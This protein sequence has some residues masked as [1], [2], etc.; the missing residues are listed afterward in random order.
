MFNYQA[1]HTVVTINQ[2]NIQTS[3]IISN[4]LLSAIS[5]GKVRIRAWAITQITT[6]SD[7]IELSPTRQQ[8][9]SHA[10]RSQVKLVQGRSILLQGQQFFYIEFEMTVPSI[11]A[12]YLFRSFIKL[13][14]NAKDKR[15]GFHPLCSCLYFNLLL[16]NLTILSLWMIENYPVTF[17]QDFKVI[18]Y[19]LTTCIAAESAT[20]SRTREVDSGF[21]R[22][23][24]ESKES[25]KQVKTNRF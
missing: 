20:D 12:L 25:R 3:T 22:D 13:A 16:A 1:N 23:C 9:N 2:T 4:M 17:P 18:I 10:L 6:I 15:Q 24:H 7:G 8:S 11:F 21:S 14:L 5:R 19:F